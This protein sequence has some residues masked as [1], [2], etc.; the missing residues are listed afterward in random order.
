MPEQWK[1]GD[2]F[3]VEGVVE[4]VGDNGAFVSLGTPS[5]PIRSYFP[6]A[7]LRRIPMANHLSEHLNWLPGDACM[8]RGIVEGTIDRT[9]LDGSPTLLLIRF[10]NGLSSEFIRAEF[11]RDLIELP[12]GRMQA[13]DPDLEHLGDPPAAAQTDSETRV[14]GLVIDAVKKGRRVRIDVEIDKAE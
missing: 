5:P 4:W 6:E 2:R 8:V 11:N 1:A 13:G 10:P 9:I 12:P 14:V 3:Q 7:D